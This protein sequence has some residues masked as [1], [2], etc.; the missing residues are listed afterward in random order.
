MTR[1]AILYILII[2][3]CLIAALAIIHVIAQPEPP[4]LVEAQGCPPQ[5]K[6]GPPPKSFL[7]SNRPHP[8]RWEERA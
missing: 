4:L 7:E 2:L 6:P 5:S 8:F 3:G 1:A